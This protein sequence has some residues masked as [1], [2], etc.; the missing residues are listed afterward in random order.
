MDDIVVVV[1]VVVVVARGR[2]ERRRATRCVVGT[3]TPFEKPNGR[4]DDDA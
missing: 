2:G 3:G 4:N 1:V